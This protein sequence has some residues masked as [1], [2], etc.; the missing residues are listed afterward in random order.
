[1][2]IYSRL[3]LV[4]LLAAASSAAWSTA[5]NLN[6]ADAATLAHSL[7]GI[8]NAKAQAIV[9]YRQ[10][11]GPFRSVDELA[12]VKGISQKLIDHNRADLRIER[13][14]GVG[15]AAAPQGTQH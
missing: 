12:Q 14:A 8:G 15:A 7:K 2:K 5:V 6:T 9:E 3:V 13:V 10:K 1:M 11:H 4:A